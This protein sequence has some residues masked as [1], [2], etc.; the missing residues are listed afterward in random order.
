MHNIPSRNCSSSGS[1]IRL[2]SLRCSYKHIT[3]KFS[4][5]HLGALNT[6][7]VHVKWLTSFDQRPLSYPYRRYVRIFLNKSVSHYIIGDRC[8]IRCLSHCCRAVRRHDFSLNPPS[9]PTSHALLS[10]HIEQSGAFRKVWPKCGTARYSW[11][12]HHC[13]APSW[14]PSSLWQ[15]D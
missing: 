5:A 15:R 13:R 11:H 4:C 14:T 7:Q 12:D 3:P 6:I 10:P 9:F 1:F 2:L 8:A